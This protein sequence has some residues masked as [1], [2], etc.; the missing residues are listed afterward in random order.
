MGRI[1]SQ[2][3]FHYTKDLNTLIS[4]LQNGF[5]GHYCREEFRYN[6]KIINIY[7]PMVSFCDI[8][9]SH[10]PDITYGGFGIGMYSVWGNAQK[11][12]PVCYF[13]KDIKCTLSSFIC[14]QANRYYEKSMQK[15]LNSS[16][17]PAILAYSKPRN[18]YT[19]SGHRSDNYVEKEWRKAYLECSIDSKMHGQI[20]PKML[21]TF[22]CNEISFIIVPDESN[23]KQLVDNIS[24]FSQIG[25]NSISKSQL[26]YVISKIITIEE[27]K[28]N[29]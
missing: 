28:K 21:L 5:R 24:P 12:T 26:Q 14:Q 22:N 18:K 2:S 29:F 1:Y 27:I 15:S 11:L 17:C 25:G 8:P 19:S 3:Y 20:H 13:P 9:L 6:Q 7:V 10:I 16:R 4:I 23:R